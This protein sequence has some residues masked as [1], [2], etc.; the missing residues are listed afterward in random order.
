MVEPPLRLGLAESLDC[1]LLHAS[2]LTAN[3]RDVATWYIE[4]PSKQSNQGL[5][6]AAF[7]GGRADADAEL[8]I[9]PAVD[10]V[11][12]AAWRQADGNMCDEH[13][14]RNKKSPGTF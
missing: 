12:T 4:D 10:R 11:A 6:R 8:P 14:P 5:I 13:G 3:D 7:E 9:A 1:Y 2:L